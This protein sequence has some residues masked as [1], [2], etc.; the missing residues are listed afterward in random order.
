MEDQCNI[1]TNR[2]SALNDNITG[3]I[4]QLS[5]ASDAHEIDNG[6]LTNIGVTG[7]LDE[8]GLSSLQ[9]ANN[10]TIAGWNWGP[11]EGPQVEEPLVTEQAARPPDT[12]DHLD[13]LHFPPLL[14][15][16]ASDMAQPTDGH[17][18]L[19]S[20][21]VAST[22]TASSARFQGDTSSSLKTCQ[23]ACLIEIDDELP[24]QHL[25]ED[26]SSHNKDDS[27][28]QYD[29]SSFIGSASGL[30]GL[31]AS[32]KAPISGQTRLRVPLGWTPPNFAKLPPKPRKRKRSIFKKSTQESS[33]SA[34]TTKRSRTVD[35]G[36]SARGF[37]D[38]I[39]S[40]GRTHGSRDTDNASESNM[41]SRPRPAPI[42]T[43]PTHKTFNGTEISK[44]VCQLPTPKS[45]ASMNGVHTAD[46]YPELASPSISKGN[47]SQSSLRDDPGK[48]ANRSGHTRTE[49]GHYTTAQSGSGQRAST[50]LT[51]HDVIV[52]SDDEEPAEMARQQAYSP[53]NQTAS[54]QGVAS[55]QHS[56]YS[57]HPSQV[58]GDYRDRSQTDSTNFITG[59]VSILDA[60]VSKRDS[61]SKHGLLTENSSIAN[62][63]STTAK[64]SGANTVDEQPNVVSQ[65]LTLPRLAARPS[66]KS[67]PAIT[68][69]IG[70]KGTSKP[71]DITGFQGSRPIT[72]PAVPTTQQPTRP[73]GKEAALLVLQQTAAPVQHR[74]T[75]Q[76]S[77]RRRQMKRTVTTRSEQSWHE[78]RDKQAMQDDIKSRKR[79]EKFRLDITSAHPDLPADEIQQR[80]DALESNKQ[81]E[82]FKRKE[83]RAAK[84]AYKN[85]PGELHHD[86]SAELNNEVEAIRK[87]T[88][89]TKPL[90]GLEPGRRIFAYRVIKTYPY[91][92]PEEAEERYVEEEKTFLEKESANDHAQAVFLNENDPVLRQA[93]EGSQLT[94]MK[95]VFDDKRGGLFEGHRVFS[96]GKKHSV[97]VDFVEMQA[98]EVQ[99]SMHRGRKLSKQ[100]KAAFT[101]VQFVVWAVFTIDQNAR[102]CDTQ[103]PPPPLTPLTKEATS[104]LMAGQIT[105]SERKVLS[106]VVSPLPR[107]LYRRYVA[108]M[109][110]QAADEEGQDEEAS[111]SL[112]PTTTAEH[113]SE[114]EVDDSD[115]E[116]DDG[117][118]NRATNG[119]TLTTKEPAIT[120]PAITIGQSEDTTGHH[121]GEDELEVEEDESVEEEHDEEGD[122]FDQNTENITYHHEMVASF[123]T[124][125]EAN[126]EAYR[127]FLGM[128]NLISLNCCTHP[129][130]TCRQ[131]GLSDFLRDN[132]INPVAEAA[133]K[134]IDLTMPDS[135]Y[136]FNNH[137]AYRLP[138]GFRHL[139]IFVKKT[140]LI[141]PLLVG[142]GLIDNTEEL[143]EEVNEKRDQRKAML[144]REEARKETKKLEE[145]KRKKSRLRKQ[146]KAVDHEL[147][148]AEI[149]HQQAQQRD[150][151]AGDIAT[152]GEQQRLLGQELQDMEDED[153]D[154]SEEE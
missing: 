19:C 90:C 24:H 109:E 70:A 4:D 44:V 87:Q 11:L 92:E 106:S 2:L 85:R 40:H 83:E 10:G 23:P 15:A 80:I 98:G 78:I 144:Q 89:L 67:L 54:S 48:A 150:S 97:I 134:G 9:N 104:L 114:D 84:N 49:A 59:T 118:H 32:S 136:Y 141:G 52:L 99:P 76:S 93:G 96:N 57:K 123:T 72:K 130:C 101:P 122:W 143:E 65:Q 17:P 154:V 50:D 28:S 47:S 146:E 113:E 152:E 38:T 30:L 73:M 77:Q 12:I 100:A 18:N 56:A 51:I 42:I 126:I 139:Q 21:E 39:Q 137:P 27:K 148:A 62:T 111:C 120:E 153:S 91:I 121:S 135:R 102:K 34:Q 25:Q 131:G 108:D 133:R 53:K 140:E 142:E 86:N 22:S 68:T 88:R 61:M 105:D 110:D 33:E 128:N 81:L 112:K 119:D 138:L 75:S 129:S 63:N 117:A 132:Q 145:L 46:Q 79:Q 26:V 71:I 6:I 43:T 107:N 82:L 55:G 66:Q 127:V 31:L 8:N 41:A 1:G 115:S 74:L 124:L 20:S 29:G 116:S 149:N 16:P 103:R 64:T 14:S 35:H 13:H 94:E 7:D 95:M 58:A 60:T 151:N 69:H 3:S 37:T 5:A 36:A 125:R 45:A 147:T